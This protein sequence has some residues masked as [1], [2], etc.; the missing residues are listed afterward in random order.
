MY[1]KYSASNVTHNLKYH[2]TSFYIHEQ[3]VIIHYQ[4]KAAWG[5]SKIS[6][7][8]YPKNSC[9]QATVCIVVFN[10]AI[11]NNNVIEHCCT[12]T[13]LLNLAYNVAC[14]VLLFTAFTVNL[15]TEYDT[16]FHK[17]YGSTTFLS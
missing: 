2:T 14:F 1:H 3:V 17:L 11:A 7:P 10:N 8:N 9:I 15:R 4:I 16:L 13:I 5:M 6:Y 12:K